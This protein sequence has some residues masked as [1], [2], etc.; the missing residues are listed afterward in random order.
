MVS[1]ASRTVPIRL[2]RS[3]KLLSHV[4]S[5][6][7]YPQFAPVAEILNSFRG[8]TGSDRALYS[9]SMI[10]AI[11]RRRRPSFT[12]QPVDPIGGDADLVTAVRTGA[13]NLKLITWQAK[14]GG[15]IKRLG[16][17]GDQAGKVKLIALS[18]PQRPPESP[19]RP[20]LH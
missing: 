19:T 20:S 13:G 3:A 17:S 1:P 6:V 15:P 7:L 2:V 16:D 8:T 5:L 14:Q 4:A 18:M 10:A 12:I 11:K 9:A